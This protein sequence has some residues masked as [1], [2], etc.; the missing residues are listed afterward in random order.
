MSKTYSFKLYLINNLKRIYHSSPF[1]V[2]AT[3]SFLYSRWC[4]IRSYWLPVHMYQGTTYNSDK[5]LRFSYLGWNFA[6]ISYWLDQIFE[7]YECISIKKRFPAW[8]LRKII[9]NNDTLKNDLMIVEITNNFIE[10]NISDVPG[11][12]LP[13]WLKMHLSIERSLSMKS[14]K[15]IQNRIGKYNLE[16]EKAFGCEDFCF[17]Y[18]KMYKPY[19][20]ARYKNSAIIEDYKKMSRNYKNGKSTIYFITRYGKR[21]AG[22]YVHN[23]DGVP[24]FHALG[25]LYNSEEIRNMGVI[26]ALYYF[27]LLDYK[28]QNIR[29]IEIGGTSPLLK[30]GLTRFKVNLGA[31][32][33]EIKKQN[34]I[35][36]KMRPFGNSSALKSFLI[37]NPFI[38]IQNHS[39]LCAAFKEE[40]IEESEIQKHN[41]K[42]NA[43]GI[44]NTPIFQ[45]NGEYNITE[46]ITN[47][48]MHKE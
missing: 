15:Q 19:I 3:Y 23:D 35:K 6:T 38:Y 4:R 33:S 28:K 29:R 41:R 40:P 18:N 1:F 20:E 39:M 27:A 10:R 26:G 44:K 13:R 47:T 25:I 42:T 2:I 16:F 22:M 30:D 24:Y 45:L 7:R 11:F 12:V 8:K 9:Y 5:I 21:I 32:V 34:S 14:F 31:M 48:K 37:S 17:F 43:L 46:C 36:L